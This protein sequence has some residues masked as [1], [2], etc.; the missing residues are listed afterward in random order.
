M[1]FPGGT[2]FPRSKGWGKTITTLS[3][4]VILNRAMRA[5]F[6]AAT[7]IRTF[8]P[9]RNARLFSRALTPAE[10]SPVGNRH[11]GHD[12]DP[13]L[14]DRGPAGRVLIPGEREPLDPLRDHIPP[15]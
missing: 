5:S 8:S 13:I 9:F 7:S 6:A 15:A 2:K 12:A 4:A 1:G 14:G 11:V 10:L 3:S